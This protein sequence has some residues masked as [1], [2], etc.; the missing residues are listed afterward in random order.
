MSPDQ[1]SVSDAALQ[2]RK[3]VMGNAPG[4]SGLTRNVRVFTITCFACIGGFLYGYNQGV[5][6]GILTMTSFGAHMGEYIT[7]STKKGWLTSILELGA[8]I[9]TLI[10]SFLVEP[11]SR[12]YTIILAACVFIIGVVV[13][14]TAVRVGY[15]AILGGRFVTGM[16]IGSLSMTV[17]M[18]VA[19]CAPPESRGLLLGIQQFAIEFGVMVSFWIVGLPK[20][21]YGLTYMK[22]LTYLLGLWL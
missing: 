18:Y 21:K 17:P 2:Y 14:S 20:S 19:E 4:V 7:N 5:F 10:S 13:Q 11:F 6:S 22:S 9:G 16:G 1:N 3:K 15:S 12:K 8:W